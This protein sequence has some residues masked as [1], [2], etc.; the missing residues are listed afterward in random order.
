M[1]KFR[2]TMTVNANDSIGALY[3]K[4]KFK[5]YAN[6]STTSFIEGEDGIY[7]EEIFGEK[8]DTA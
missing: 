1:K 3:V 7:V 5:F 6:N 4:D 2:I 8:R